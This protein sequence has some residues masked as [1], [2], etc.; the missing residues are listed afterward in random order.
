MNPQDP[1][2]RDKTASGSPPDAP[3]KKP[4]K[5][6]KALLVA[7]ILL[8]VAIVAVTVVSVYLHRWDKG[9][10]E[11]G[12]DLIGTV[13]WLTESTELM[14]RVDALKADGKDLVL[15]LA[16]QDA[17]EAEL[18]RGR[19]LE[20]AE[21]LRLYLGTPL[22][23]AAYS[24]PGV[25]D[26]LYTVDALL[27]LLDEADG[28]MIAPAVE[29]VK[30]HPLA[31]LSSPDGVRVDILKVY[32]DFLE[33]KLP[34]AKALFGKLKQLDL[35]LFDSEGKLDE[36]M[37]KA[38]ALFAAADDASRYLPAIRAVLGDGSDRLYLFAAQNSSE[39]RASGGFPGS[40]GCIRIRGDYLTISDFR[41]VYQVL[42][43]AT[44]SQA[45]VT[46][47]DD[48]LFSGRLHLSWDADFSPDFERVASI[49][50]MAYEARQHEHVDGVVSGTPAIIP[51][52]LS[53][54]GS[55][56]LS[57]G[58]ELTG[59]NAGRVLGHDLYFTYLG[60]SQ[61]ANSALLVDALFS[62]AAVGTLHLLLDEIRVGILPELLQFVR[63]STADRTLMLWMAD[64][65]EQELVREAGW[66]AG[67]NTDPAHPKAGIFFNS[68]VA[69][70]TAW[71]LDI[72]PELSEPVL[73]EDGSRTYEL[74]VRLS[75]VMTPEEREAASA[76]I[77]GDRDAIVGSLYLLAPAG[78][79]LDEAWQSNGRPMGRAVYEGLE[80]AY[81]LEISVRRG[82]PRFVTCRITTAPGAEEPLGLMS[83]PTM[84]QFR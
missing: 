67:L 6:R 62:E 19:M 72:E 38:D 11:P 40:V 16:E 31:D 65:A 39:I 26:Q 52:L 82:E 70:K 73:N 74:T 51:R 10:W 44:P 32:L 28:A 42:Q 36:Y 25:R 55:V 30:A 56:T 35:H 66:N 75:N 17:A 4:K 60:R 3:D 22:M 59:E 50:A 48:Q 5:R 61:S 78:G 79:H 7:A 57:D 20:D 80:M 43:M 68:T 83:T 18:A 13:R 46:Y 24:T 81:L 53:F 47:L 69:S 76:Y 54:L 49:W 45:G 12:E 14:K 71:F 41:S 63:E 2:S 15:H 84:Q 27:D 1:T 9:E 37:E 64:E 34:D 77:L 58:T 21:G 33:Q 8:L 23:Q 29:L